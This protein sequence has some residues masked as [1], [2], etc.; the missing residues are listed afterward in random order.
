VRQ[1]RSRY[2]RNCIF[3]GSKAD[4]R[5]HFW[6]NWALKR[7]ATHVGLYSTVD[8]VEIYHPNQKAVRVKCVCEAC[9]TGWMKRL[10]DRVLAPIS[11]MMQD[12]SLQLDAQQQK[13][14][15]RWAFKNAMV[16]EYLTDEDREDFFTDDERRQLADET[17]P[18]IPSNSWAWLS[19][20]KGSNAFLTNSADA[21]PVTP[22]GVSDLQ[23]YV[24]T[25]AFRALAIQVF[26]V[27]RKAPANTDAVINADPRFSSAVIQIWPPL[28]NVSWPP[29]L[30]VDD[31]SFDGLHSRF[32]TGK[33][34][35]MR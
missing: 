23:G 2:V 32:A 27:R 14:I 21:W 7:F 8:D 26:S 6:S 30:S 31:G 11:L 10:E 16:L 25:L 9:N 33:R 1:I 17:H 28:N 3:C 20:Y 29:A 19:R 18:S 4:S 34:P 13:V 15:T 35:L 12:V 5:E 24:M 22:D